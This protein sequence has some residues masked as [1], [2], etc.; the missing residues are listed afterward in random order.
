MY[1]VA[2]SKALENPAVG[3]LTT[4]AKPRK[5]HSFVKIDQTVLT[6]PEVISALHEQELKKKVKKQENTKK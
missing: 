1:P 6:G 4:P 3:G 5:K 2:M